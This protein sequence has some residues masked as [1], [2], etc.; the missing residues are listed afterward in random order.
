M[1]IGPRPD[2]YSD[3]RSWTPEERA[4]MEEDHWRAYREWIA[5]IGRHRDMAPAQIDSVARGRVW[6]G[7]QARDRGLID[8]VGDLE[9][10]VNEARKEAG[11]GEGEGVTL[12]HLPKPRGFL[13][14]L[15]GMEMSAL[16][17]GLISR[18]MSERVA[19]LETIGRADLQL[20]EAPVP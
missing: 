9:F 6:T 14:T 18:W 11:L 4:I 15:V 12:V 7:E 2:F 13:S 3:Y 16:P 1:G 10:A 20:L 19:F 8:A 17:Q 5:D